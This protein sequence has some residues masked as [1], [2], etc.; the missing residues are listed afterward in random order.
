MV[1][2]QFRVNLPRSKFIRQMNTYLFILLIHNTVQTATFVISRILY[3]F[4]ILYL[5]IFKAF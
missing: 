1:I 5:V 4:H 2:L 3:Y